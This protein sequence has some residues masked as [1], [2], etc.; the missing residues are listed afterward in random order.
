MNYCKAISTLLMTNDKLF[1][2]DGVEKAD[3][4]L[5]RSL[6]GSLL[7]LTA[8]RPDILY[9]TSLLSRFMQSPSQIHFGAAKRILK[10]LR[11]TIDYN[12]W[13]RPSANAK[14]IGYT[15]SD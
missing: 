15:D 14:L 10:Y 6:T 13:Y 3:A 5:Y 7:Y 1:K 9:V 8:T 2:E 12:I 4:S 11:G